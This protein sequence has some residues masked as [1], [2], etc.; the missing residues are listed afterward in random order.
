[1]RRDWVDQ[2]G[3]SWDGPGHIAHE[4]YHHSYVDAEWSAR[5]IQDE[6]FV[7]AETCLV[8]HMHPTWGKAE[9]DATYREGMRH[10][11]R[12]RRLFERRRSQHMETQQ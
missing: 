3:A 6:A 4:G 7:F 5:A 10:Y 11:D 9:T 2:F 1:M 12:D 8:E